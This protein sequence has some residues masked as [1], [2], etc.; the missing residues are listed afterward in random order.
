MSKSFLLTLILIFSSNLDAQTDLSWPPPPD[1]SRIMFV[2]AIDCS[3]LNRQSGLWSRIKKL[4]AGSEKIDK[5]SLPFDLVKID[6]SLFLICQNIPYLI[7]IDLNEKSFKFYND[8]ENPFSYPI[9]L[10]R[11]GSGTLF[12]TD[13]ENSTVYKYENEKVKAF[14]KG[15]LIRPTGIT[16]NEKDKN[17]FIVDT[18]E[19]S[20]KIFN[21][22]GEYIREIGKRGAEKDEFN[23]PTFISMDNNEMLLINDSMNYKIKT[24]DN[25]GNLIES[26]GIEGD[27]LGAFSRPKVIAVDSDN[28]IYVVDNLLDRIQVFDNFGNLLVVIGS[29]GY[30]RGQ[31]WSPAGLDILNDTLWIADTFNNRIQVLHYIKEESK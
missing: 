18:G 27:G 9:S 21:F 12:I 4:I 2:D 8:K 13:S 29:R 16:A 15:N 7:K 19:H 31:F 20:I 17:I 26:F 3:T 1:Q 5:L 10:C 22:N 23:Y 11:G 14:I 28:N 6:N 30:D 24:V 25:L